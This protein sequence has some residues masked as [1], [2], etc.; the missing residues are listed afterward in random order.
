[1]TSRTKK[2]TVC[3][4][5]IALAT[6][7]SMVKIFKMPLGGSV[8][9]LSMLPIVLISVMYSLSWGV[10][11]AG[12]YAVIQLFL[13]ITLDGLLGW[14]LTPLMLVGTIILDYLLP[15]TLL[16][17][18]GVFRKKG[19]AGFVLGTVMVL[20]LRF[21]C[22]FISGYV[23]FAYLDQFEVFGNTFVGKPA[24]YSVC[25]NALYMLPELVLTTIG[26]AL[27]FKSK[28]VNKLLS[29]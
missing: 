1:M 15:F 28:A 19:F 16:G 24:L 18:A 3:A 2:M 12:I 7:L 4:I 21:V 20:V 8:T 6:V 11:S 17:L 9:L 25:Y 22:H 29:A 5:M 27:V 13:G 14:G 26:T 10:A 23:I